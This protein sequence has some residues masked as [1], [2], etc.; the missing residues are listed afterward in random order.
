MGHYR[1]R[2][3]APDAWRIHKKTSAWVTK[4]APGP[5]NN[6]A[7][8]IAVWLRDK[9][10]L[11]HTMH[12]VKQILNQRTVI[13]NGRVVTDPSIGIG[14]FDVIS[15]PT[16][17][18]HYR[19]LVDEKGHLYTQEISAENAQLRLSKIRDKTVMPGGKVQ[20]NLFFGANLLADNTY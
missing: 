6:D 20:L 19:V 10:E 9:M 3:T 12:E 14:I 8:P 11:A 1:K 16:L 4:T 5:H 7:M 17:D 13:L 2:L 18:K 15:I